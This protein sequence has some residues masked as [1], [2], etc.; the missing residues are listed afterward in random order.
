MLGKSRC[1]FRDKYNTHKNS[2]GRMCS[3]WTLNLL[4]HQV[5]SGLPEAKTP[6]TVSLLCM[7]TTWTLFLYKLFAWSARG[8]SAALWLSL[9]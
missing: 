6:F 7:K 5:T 3:S 9:F 1:L 2:V 8:S 4:V